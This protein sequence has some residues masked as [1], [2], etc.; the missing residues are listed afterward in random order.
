MVCKDLKYKE[1]KNK[2]REYGTKNFMRDVGWYILLLPWYVLM[3]RPEL[4]GKICKSLYVAIFDNN[5]HVDIQLLSKT[6]KIRIWRI[7]YF[8]NTQ[9]LYQ[10]FT[11][12]I[13]ISIVEKISYHY[14]F[15]YETVVYKFFENYINVPFSCRLLLLGAEDLP[16]ARSYWSFCFS[17]RQYRL[18]LA[19]LHFLY[20]IY[21]RCLLS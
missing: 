13:Y 3:R 4:I 17:S 14:G 10:V 11:I 15:R 2:T 12:R 16:L 20:D 1:L 7:R 21:R 19:T 9:I 5:N 8:E 18:L 6:F